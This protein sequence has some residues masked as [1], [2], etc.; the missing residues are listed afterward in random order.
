MKRYE[1]YTCSS[2]IFQGM[3]KDP[4][5]DYVE[6][7]DVKVLIDTVKE[8]VDMLENLS[9]ITLDSS[10]NETLFDMAKLLKNKVGK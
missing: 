3:K 10:D 9:G 5:G 7:D 6:F 2:E 8:I 1:P 4:D